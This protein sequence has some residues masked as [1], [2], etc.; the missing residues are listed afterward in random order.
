M[1]GYQSYIICTTP[2]SGST[3]L[4]RMLS[5]TGV[6]GHPK[7]WFHKADIADWLCYL[8]LPQVGG[9][10]E[11]TTLD[12][13]MTTVLTRGCGGTDLFALRLQRKSFDFLNRKLDVLY[14]GLP[15]D[16]DRFQAAFG[17]T[18]FIHL[19]RSDKVDQAISYVMASQ[20][21]LWHRNS[22]GSELE[23]LSDPQPPVYDAALIQRWMDEMHRLDTEWQSWF[24][25]HG[26]TPLSL[27]YEDLSRDPRSTLAKI[28]KTL[29]LNETIAQTTTP[30]TAKLADATSLEWKE[31]FLEETVR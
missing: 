24:E 28:L 4:C 26:I 23:R 11:T 30:A 13:I 2:R 27:T 31:R 5:D 15:T 7:S 12:S 19:T 9:E 3:L 10:S 22:D 14:P 1:P 17:R 25:A 21:G 20:T 6:A 8:D 29:G 18:L 16:M